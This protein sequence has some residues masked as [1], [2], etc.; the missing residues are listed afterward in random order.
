[1]PSKLKPAKLR[2]LKAALERERE[3][4]RETAEGT[5]EAT[6]Q[7]TDYQGEESDSAGASGDVGSELFEQ[8]TM[9]TLEHMANTRLQEIEA[10]LGRMERG[11][12]GTCTNCGREI[13]VERLEVH[14]WS[15]LCVDCAR[16]Q[17]PA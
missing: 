1:M 13:P 2:E 6:R 17:R 14:P 5:H 16:Q 9:L 12:Y 4:Q 7:L 15:S 3:R 11:E 8:E 10:A